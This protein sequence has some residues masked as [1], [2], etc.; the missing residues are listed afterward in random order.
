MLEELF[1]SG[2]LNIVYAIIF[3]ISFIFALISVVGAELGDIL[4]FDV[5]AESDGIFNFVSISPFALAMFGSIFGMVG[6]LTR[7]WL[8]MDAIPSIL[9]SAGSGVIIGIGA[10]AFFIYILSPNKS[11]HYSLTEDAVGR[12]V[13][14]I[15]SIP[16]DGLGQIAP[17]HR[18]VQAISIA[19][20]A[21]TR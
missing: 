21:V 9:W 4:D 6:L 1:A 12:E 5:D 20:I 18:D 15:I 2:P 10:Q 3:A 16:G 11:S 7:L 13:E 17:E 14:V 8:E 19:G